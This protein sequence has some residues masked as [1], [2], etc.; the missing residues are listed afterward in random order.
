MLAAAAAEAEEAEEAGAD[1]PSRPR[2]PT[3]VKRIPRTLPKPGEPLPAWPASLGSES[4]PPPTPRPSARRSQR[5]RALLGSK[6]VY[7]GGGAASAC[8]GC[9]SGGK[10]GF[11]SDGWRFPHLLAHAAGGNVAAPPEALGADWP[12]LTAW[13]TATINLDRPGPPRAARA[14]A[15]RFE[16]V[17]RRLL[18]YA[19]AMGRETEL[20]EALA[21]G[22]LILEF[23]FFLT[24]HRRGRKSSA[25]QK[26][27]SCFVP[28]TLHS[29]LARLYELPSFP[30]GTRPS[31]PPRT[32][33]AR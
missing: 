29:Q 2:P 26:V 14:W 32:L 15:E 10:S 18:G 21:D 19:A 11:H 20:A 30:S 13:A 22:P 3:A 27:C 1:V 17:A 5:V 16:G 31:A 23:V 4:Q 28:S 12:K 9:R 8:A 33:C 25:A 7:V 6:R 24:D